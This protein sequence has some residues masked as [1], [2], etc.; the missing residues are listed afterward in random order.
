MSFLETLYDSDIRRIFTILIY[1]PSSTSTTTPRGPTMD[2]KRSRLYRVSQAVDV[3]WLIS[4]EWSA[5]AGNMVVS[6]E[7][8]HHRRPDATDALQSAELPRSRNEF[9]RRCDH[10]HMTFGFGRLLSKWMR[11]LIVVKST[12]SRSSVR[13]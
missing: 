10:L 3:E 13:I 1:E 5:E 8:H 9:A 4:N 6:R 11:Q 12:I 7:F 2:P